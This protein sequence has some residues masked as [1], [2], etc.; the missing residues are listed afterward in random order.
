MTTNI[1]NA[2][3]RVYARLEH[4][5]MKVAEAMPADKY[6]FKPSPDVRTF[7]EQLRHIGAVQ[8]VVG[9]GLF[10]KKAPV[11]VGDGDSGPL[12]MTTKADILQYARDSFAYIRRAIE[13]VSDEN[14][15]EMIPHPYDPENSK[16]ERLALVVS[17][18][19]HGWEHYGQMIVYQRMNGI[20]PPPSPAVRHGG[21]SRCAHG[22]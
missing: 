19:S 9:A 5:L 15:L 10:G 22:P 3:D 14:A 18:A 17:Y 4:Q 13:T 2:L 12:S 16:L 21:R 6:S 1:A 7:G 11:E 20:V 8:W